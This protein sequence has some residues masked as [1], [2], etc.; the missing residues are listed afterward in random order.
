MGGGGAPLVLTLA[1]GSP[2][3]RALLEALGYPLRVVP[4]R[5]AEEGLALPPWELALALA[6]RKGESVAGAWVLAAD[7]VVDLEGEAL[8]KPKD[9]EENRAFLRRLSGREH[10]VHTGLYL[11]TPQ[12]TVLE[13]HTAKVRFRPLSEEEIAWYVASG[14]GLDKAGG[15]GA[16]GLGMALLEGV[17]G[18]FYTVVGLPVARVFALLWARGFRP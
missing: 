5:V 2:R 1:S 14:E 16:Q 13:V 7:T 9:P 11:R 3:R 18:D 17:E 10:R 6:W 15:Y 4:P 12:D 8:G